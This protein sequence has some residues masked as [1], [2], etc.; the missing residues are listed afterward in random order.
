MEVAA[1]AKWVRVTARKA[2]VMTGMVEG[3]PVSDAL[4]VLRFTPRHAATEIAKV[5]KSAAANAEHNYNLDQSS[6]R[7]SRVEVEG[8]MIIK[9]FRPKPRGMVGSIYKRTS[10]LRAY[11][12]DDELPV[13]R[14]KRP[15]ARAP[16]RPQVAARTVA[17]PA[18]ATAAPAE[19]AATP[20]E[21][22][23]TVEVYGDSTPPAGGGEG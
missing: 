4:N 19:T 12:T 1:T 13:R 11:V 5:I 9:R 14:S 18:S 20:D 22:E 23:T 21:T 16:Q 10:H 2:R 15:I 6:L 8:A 3:L 17:A 7:V